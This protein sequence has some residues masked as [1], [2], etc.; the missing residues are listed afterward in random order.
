MAILAGIVGCNMAG[1]LAGCGGAVMAAGAVSGDTRVIEGR[2]GPGVGGMAIVAGIGALNVV[3][4]FAGGY[5]AVV[6]A[7]AGADHVGMIDMERR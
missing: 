6:A 1:A 7:E 5:G 2:P 3:C 4:R